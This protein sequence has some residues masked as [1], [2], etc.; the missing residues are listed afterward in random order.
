MIIIDH[1]NRLTE[2]KITE[3]SQKC[4]CELEKWMSEFIKEND[5]KPIGENGK[6]II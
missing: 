1:P 6:V 3:E 2:K 4:L 5:I